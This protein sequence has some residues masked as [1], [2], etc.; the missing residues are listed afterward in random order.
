MRANG[1]ITLTTDFG[2]LDSYVGAMKGVVLGIAPGAQLID[3]THT[4][5]PQNLHQAA[6]MIQSFYAYFPI[7]SV[8]L[9]AIDPGASNARRPI[10]L[11]TPEAAFVAPDNGVLT[12]IWREALA[13]WGAAACLVVELNRPGYWRENVSNTFHARDIF[14]PVAAYLA[15]GTNV[16]ELGAVID[17]MVEANLEQPTRGRG[18]E[19][20]GRIIH[21][22]AVG[23][24]VT[25][26]RPGHLL[27]TGLLDQPLIQVIDQQIVGVQRTYTDVARGDLLALFGS[28][29][30][31]EVALRN[32]NAAKRLGVGI[33]DTVRV[34]GV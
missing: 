32:G 19:L 25:N 31:L 4:I 20:V 11:L 18:G 21:I 28:T 6:Y 13:R 17:A 8:H 5:E 16:R 24:C 27:E 34:R 7:G 2:V 33:G 23:N 29:D 12:Y 9:V 10:V 22:D 1:I 3:I 15:R 14:A 30:H 26:I